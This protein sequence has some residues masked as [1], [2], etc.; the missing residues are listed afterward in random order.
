M[1]TKKGSEYQIVYDLLSNIANQC[2]SMRK[3]ISSNQK[4][5]RA[6][7]DETTFDDLSEIRSDLEMLRKKAQRFAIDSQI[8]MR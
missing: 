2:D 3:E 4:S 7:I 1:T 5:I 6:N 8:I